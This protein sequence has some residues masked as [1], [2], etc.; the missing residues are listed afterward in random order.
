MNDRIDDQGHD[1]GYDEK[2]ISILEQDARVS[3]REIA[4]MLDVSEGLV[5]KRLRR[6]IET[7]ELKLGT[8]VSATA[9]G[10]TCSAFLRLSVAPE[11]VTA[12][13]QQLAALDE[14]PFVGLAIGRFDVFAVTLTADRDALFRLLRERIDPLPG[15]SFVDVR[16]IMHVPK[17]DRT[18]I[19]IK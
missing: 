2:I 4:R 19:R 18:R 14:I 16:E 8:Q 12:V 3:N 15:V 10:L 13:A 11:S 1:Q 9:M 5:R 6:L 7:Q 17:Y